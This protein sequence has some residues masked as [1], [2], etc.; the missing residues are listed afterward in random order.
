MIDAIVNSNTILVVLAVGLIIWIIRQILPDRIENH[1]V[2][3][4][5]LR[6]LP[7]A[8]GAGVAMIPGL[9]PMETMIQCFVLG[10]VAGSLS[11]SLYGILREAL[12]EKMKLL[13]GSRAT[14][15]ASATDV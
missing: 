15:K 6:F 8:L 10:A 1:K 5:V 7:I 3:K 13:L 2:W 14:R 12:G 9:R 11:S 4:V